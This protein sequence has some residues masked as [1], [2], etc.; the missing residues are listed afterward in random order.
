MSRWYG[1]ISRCFN[2]VLVI[3]VREVMKRSHGRNRLVTYRQD[4]LLSLP[5]ERRLRIMILK[6]G[7]QG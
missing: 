4:P 7:R 2:V 1:A 5:L 3:V 6:D